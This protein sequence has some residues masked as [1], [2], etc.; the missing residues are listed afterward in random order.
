MP[1]S[2]LFTSSLVFL[3]II[4]LSACSEEKVVEVGEKLRPV[5]TIRMQ[6]SDAMQQ[7][8]F[9]GVVD[10]IQKA[11]LSF[12]VSGKLSTLDGKEG[13]EVKKGQIVATLD[14]KDFEIQL[15]DRQASFD[16]ANADFSRAAK[17][18]EAGHV[19]RSDFDKLKASLGTAKAQLE[20]AQQN[21]DYSILKAPFAG[22]IAKRYVENFEEVSAQQVI[23]LLQDTSSL[24]VSIDIPENIMINSQRGEGHYRLFAEFAAI[25]G[26][27]FP[28]KIKEVA[29]VAD[30]VTQTY[31]ISFSMAAPT[32][33]TILPGMSTTVYVE[34]D[35]DQASDMANRFFL[36]GH[37]VLQDSQGNYV[38][39]VKAVEEGVGVVER[40]AIT[41]GVPN[42]KGI[43]ILDG[44]M[45]GEQVIVAGMSKLTD[46]QRVRLSGDQQ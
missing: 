14:S 41:V 38:M 23:F 9:P 7:R 43:E 6:F 25:P 3:S 20:L 1:L 24:V 40:R 33:H 12:R 5:K 22:I 15:A 44:I 17:L 35:L 42:V 18:V 29:T 30:D 11:T 27:R 2:R 34:A 46:G 10:A 21:V 37:A 26:E 28:L 19:S 16:S 4:L 36:P 45:Q 31:N 32:D 39:L 13:E 8:Q